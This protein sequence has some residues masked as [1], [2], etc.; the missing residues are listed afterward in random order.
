MEERGG[1]GGGCK[2]LSSTNYYTTVCIFLSFS[3]SQ[4]FFVLFWKK[5]SGEKSRRGMVGWGADLFPKFLLF[6]YDA[7]LFWIFLTLASLSSLVHPTTNGGMQTGSSVGMFTHCIHV[8]C[9]SGA[10]LYC[11][12][13]L[14]H[15]ISSS[16]L[17]GKFIKSALLVGQPL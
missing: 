4:V 11:Q 14:I 2:V 6:L 3:M 5:K 9:T 7:C 10:D 15:K 13:A 8:F 1:G 17:S 12:L 16:Q